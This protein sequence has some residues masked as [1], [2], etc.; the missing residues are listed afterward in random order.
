MSLSLHLVCFR[1]RWE[2]S[3]LQSAVIQITIEFMNVQ[4]TFP[5]GFKAIGTLYYLGSHK[6]GGKKCLGENV[7]VCAHVLVSTWVSLDI[8]IIS[9]PSNK[10]RKRHAIILRSKKYYLQEAKATYWDFI[11]K[12]TSSLLQINNF[13]QTTQSSQRELCLFSL[14]EKES[15]SKITN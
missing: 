11:L 8:T 6:G 13:S 12:T 4:C 2:N 15:I 5:V 7:C 3:L 14:P 9:C 10:V 1:L